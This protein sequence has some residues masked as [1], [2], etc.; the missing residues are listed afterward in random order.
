MTD[1]ITLTLP[2]D[3]SARV[4]Q[5]SETTSQPVEQIVFDHL[6]S[7]SIQLPPLRPDDQVEL[8]A[9]HHLSDDALWTIA[10]EQVPEDAQ[11]RAHTLMNKNSLGTI[12]DAEAVELEKLVQR[13]DR[14][15]LRK[16]EAATILKERG[17]A[18]SQKDFRPQDE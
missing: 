4:R 6:K 9:L 11:A 14:V 12:T 15:M 8:D 10:R 16:A 2:E 13:A 1:Q 18:F 17:F 5:I 3:I 7:L